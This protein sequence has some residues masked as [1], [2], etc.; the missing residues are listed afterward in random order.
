MNQGVKSLVPLP[1]HTHGRAGRPRSPAPSPVHR[2]LVVSIE[3]PG[4]GARRHLEVHSEGQHRLGSTRPSAPTGNQEAAP[5][6]L[7]FPTESGWLRERRRLVPSDA[8]FHHLGFR[9]LQ[10]PA[11]D[12]LPASGSRRPGGGQSEE[13]GA[14]LWERR[15]CF[16][17]GLFSSRW[18]CV[19]LCTLPEIMKSKS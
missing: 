5:T 16:P 7:P 15:G 4:E 1:L 14:V 6:A 12:V 17:L 19:D 11:P 2:R 13:G 18:D 8:S 9:L 10:V 3:G